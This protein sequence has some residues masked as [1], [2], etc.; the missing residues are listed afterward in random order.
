MNSKE[1]PACPI[2]QFGTALQGSKGSKQVTQAKQLNVAI[3]GF[4]RIGESWVHALAAAAVLMKLMARSERMNSLQMPLNPIVQYVLLFRYCTGAH[5]QT[6]PIA[7][8]N[9]LRCVEGRTNSNLNIVVIN[10]SGEDSTRFIWVVKCFCSISHLVMLAAFRRFI[11]VPLGSI[12]RYVWRFRRWCEAGISPTQVRFHP[13]NLR[14]R[15]QVRTR[16]SLPLHACRIIPTW[17]ASHA[18]S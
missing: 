17:S 13:G 14:R 4:G 2:E 18:Q 11:T 5:L 10:D 16:P 8:R 15:H 12:L 3:N 1:G 7:G 9:F 6:L